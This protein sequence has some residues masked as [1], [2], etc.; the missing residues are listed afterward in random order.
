[1]LVRHGETEVES[2]NQI[3]RAIDVPINDNGREQS[4]KA[5]ELL[6]VPLDFAVSSPMLR[7]KKTAEIILNITLLC[8]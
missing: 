1:L 6:D 5:A 2:P 4:H 7:P 8:S 3:S